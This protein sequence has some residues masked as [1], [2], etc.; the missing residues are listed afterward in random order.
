MGKLN[1]IN[2][3]VQ[4]TLDKL[5][6]I[7]A[8]LVRLDTSWQE[9]T[10]PQL[11]EALREWAI[12]NPLINQE[13]RRD[14]LSKKERLLQINQHRQKC[15]YCNADNHISICCNKITAVDKRKKILKEKK[16]CYNCSRK[17]HSANECRRK[18]SCSNC[19]QR[20]HTSICNKK[21]ESVPTLISSEESNVI[22]PASILLWLCW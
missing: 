9:W 11:V 22:Y 19:N 13:S 18:R 14:Q 10:F 1:Q 6:R 15:V 16:L 3:Y 2:G 21:M 7:R 17:Y 8:D 20:H 12:R 4:F 5:P